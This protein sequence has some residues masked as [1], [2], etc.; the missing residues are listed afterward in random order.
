MVCPEARWHFHILSK[1]EQI[2]SL[3]KIEVVKCL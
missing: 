2:D 3:A 1:I